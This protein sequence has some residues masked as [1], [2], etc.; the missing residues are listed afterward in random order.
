LNNRKRFKILGVVEDAWPLV[1]ATNTEK[2]NATHIS[3]YRKL[4]LSTTFS[5]S[6]TG[7]GA[8]TQGALYLV[9]VGT[10][11]NA[12]ANLVGFQGRCRVRFQG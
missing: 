1:P 12:T 7:I 9:L 8:I 10:Q 3:M 5:S 4:N 6:S 2:E 11:D